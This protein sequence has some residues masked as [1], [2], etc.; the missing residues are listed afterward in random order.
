MKEPLDW[1]A[2]EM[3]VTEASN[4]PYKSQPKSDN[5]KAHNTFFHCLKSVINKDLDGHSLA[6]LVPPPPRYEES[7]SQPDYS[8]T[9]STSQSVHLQTAPGDPIPNDPFSLMFKVREEET[10]Q[11]D[12]LSLCTTPGL[13]Q[14]SKRYKNSSQTQEK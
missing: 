11:P 13:S 9:A 6:L 7:A 1:V 14:T 2:N 3:W 8:E 12:S 10:D 4:R 5:A